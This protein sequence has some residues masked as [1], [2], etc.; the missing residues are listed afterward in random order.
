MS[1]KGPYFE[2]IPDRRDTNSLKWGKYSGRTNSFMG[3]GHG[4]QVSPE[5]VERAAKEAD[6]GNF[7]YAKCPSGL[8]DAL[9]KGARTCTVGKSS[10]HGS[11]GCQ[12][13]FAL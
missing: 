3:C 11:F 7:G 1:N 13:W 9:S 8:I 4:F 6:F 12:E 10:R 5:V 2:D